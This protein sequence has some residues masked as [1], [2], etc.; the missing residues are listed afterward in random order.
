MGVADELSRS[1][2]RPPFVSR[3]RVGSP[4]ELPHDSGWQFHRNEEVRWV[5]VVLA[6][7]VDDPNIAFTTSFAVRQHLINLS[8]F[9][10]LH[11]AIFHT[12]RERAGRLP[13]SHDR[14]SR[15]RIP[16]PVA[17]TRTL[18]ISPTTFSA[19][20]TAGRSS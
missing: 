19:S 13:N 11:A 4:A 7:F 18:V 12:E 2:N 1:T 15:R 3:S 10:I 9:Q 16:R 20:A 5:D 6:G 8:D 17:I 14:Q